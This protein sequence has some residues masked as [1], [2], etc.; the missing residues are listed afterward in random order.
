[1]TIPPLRLALIVMLITALCLGG[2]WTDDTCLA[3][4]L[5]IPLHDER[6]RHPGASKVLGHATLAMTQKYAHF[7]PETLAKVVNL[8][9]LA[10]LLEAKPAVAEVG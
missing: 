8:N 2:R 10:T 1:M 3:A 6:R 7:S 4:H 5:R 9:P